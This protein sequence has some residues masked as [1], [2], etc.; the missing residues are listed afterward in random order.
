MK[1][2]LIVKDPKARIKVFPSH[3]EIITFYAVQ[4]VG[5]NQM[6][7]AYINKRVKLTIEDAIAISDKVP[8]Y[9]ID[10]HGNIIGRLCIKR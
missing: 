5:F 10:Q 7:S 9:F 6:T 2:T 1:R 4:L 3:L 8:L